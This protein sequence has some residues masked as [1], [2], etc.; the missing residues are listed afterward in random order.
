MAS[1]LSIEP[2]PQRWRR[3]RLR[4]IERQTDKKM[5]DRML[6]DRKVDR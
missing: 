4:Q 6:G 5:D 2:S 1:D 3:E